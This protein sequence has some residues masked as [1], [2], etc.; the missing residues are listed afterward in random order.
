MKKAPAKSRLDVILK[1]YGEMTGFAQKTVQSAISM[2]E[3]LVAQK[4]SCSHGDWMTWAR[5]LP[6]KLRTAEKYMKLWKNRDDPKIANGANLNLSAAYE[7]L[8]PRGFDLAA[9]F[10]AVHDP[11][12]TELP[13]LPRKPNDTDSFAKSLAEKVKEGPIETLGDPGK[14][15]VKEH[16]GIITLRQ[17]ISSAMGLFVHDPARAAEHVAPE[18][19]HSLGLQIERAIE[20]LRRFQPPFLPPGPRI[21]R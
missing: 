4:K 2:G 16:G 11:E 18:E 3:Q 10:E 14:E 17:T 1:L 5:G 12:R 21:L 13:A 9:A 7:L 6:F 19:R 15:R 8:A 20:Q